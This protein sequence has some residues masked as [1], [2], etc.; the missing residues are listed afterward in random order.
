M[1]DDKRKYT[2]VPYLHICSYSFMKLMQG[3]LELLVTV[4]PYMVITYTNFSA[5]FHGTSDLP[6]EQWCLM[7][8]AH[9]AM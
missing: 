6:E 3:L 8:M 5:P 9:L 1:D 7:Y 4:T 2:Q